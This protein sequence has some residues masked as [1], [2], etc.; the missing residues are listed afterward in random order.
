VPILDADPR[1]LLELAQRAAHE[2]GSLVRRKP[3][4]PLRTVAKSSPTD[5]VTEM[6]HASEKLIIEMILSVRPEDGVIAEEGSS[7]PSQS[8]F[9]WLIDPI[10]GT[11]N[12]LRGL[13]NYSISIA[14]VNEN[15]P[16]VGVVY[17]PTLDE[18][19]TAI[20]GHGAVLNG[21][22]IAC[23]TT[24]LAEAVIATGFSY[25]S[26]Q[27]AVQAEV[28]R[29]VLPAV[30]DIRRPGSA[31]ISLCWVAC[32]RLDAFFESGLQ[33]WD[34][35]AGAL[36]ALEAGADI[37]G[38]EMYL[39]HGELIVASAPTITA[40]LRQILGRRDPGTI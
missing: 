4:R 27:R 32:G 3:T 40:G 9:N 13:P 1:D 6:D 21:S 2:A 37:Q 18:T 15:K 33:P 24:P 39:P 28:L 8:G 19:F 35:A 23:A 31:A 12:Y 14:A 17:D 25:S 11:V 38:V 10:D 29:T 26:A 36:I 30:A 5:L 20:R 7:R 22:P 34:F 16:V